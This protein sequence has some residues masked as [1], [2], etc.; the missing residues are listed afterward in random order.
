MAELL[1]F[2]NIM[3]ATLLVHEGVH[4]LSLAFDHEIHLYDRLSVFEDVLLLLNTEWIQSFTNPGQECLILLILEEC[5][6]R[7]HLFV[8]NNGKFNL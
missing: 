6:L 8:Y 3:I 2:F 4:E 7:E 1:T 5:D